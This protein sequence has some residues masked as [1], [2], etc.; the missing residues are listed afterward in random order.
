MFAI[1]SVVNGKSC[2]GASIEFGVPRSTLKNKYKKFLEDCTQPIEHQ[3]IAGFTRTFSDE[4]EIALKSII[5]KM[6]NKMYGLSLDEVCEIAYEYAKVL[7]VKHQFNKNLKMAG[8]DWMQ[9]FKERHNLSSRQAEHTAKARFIG[10]SKDAVAHFFEIHTEVMD[11]YEFPR[12]RFYNVDET[13][14]H[15]SL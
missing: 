4:Q 1:S 11:K 15:Y 9:S 5:E 13:G 2:N 7:E 14:I 10:Y 6:E 12:D 8:E 3:H